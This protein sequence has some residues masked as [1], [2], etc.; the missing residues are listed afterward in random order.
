MAC[1]KGTFLFLVNLQVNYCLVIFLFVIPAG[2]FSD[3]K[4]APTKR[5][6][7]RFLHLF[8]LLRYPYGLSELL[9]CNIFYVVYTVTWVYTNVPSRSEIL[10][11]LN[12]KI[13]TLYPSAQTLLRPLIV[14][15]LLYVITSRTFFFQNVCNSLSKS[16]KTDFSFIQILMICILLLKPCPGFL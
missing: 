4:N 2:I 8:L 3:S 13:S 14:W 12:T 11:Y 5:G 9:Y 15:V 10:A 6:S 1:W 7:V 16:K